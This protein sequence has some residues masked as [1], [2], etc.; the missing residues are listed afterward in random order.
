MFDHQIKTA[1]SLQ[2]AEAAQGAYRA[3]L[4]K[5]WDHPE[6]KSYE[7]C[8]LK[9]RRLAEEKALEEQLAGI[10]PDP[11]LTLLEIAK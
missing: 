5:R 8:W 10:I 7:K 3:F 11:T 1:N 6:L 9:F 4:G 2:L